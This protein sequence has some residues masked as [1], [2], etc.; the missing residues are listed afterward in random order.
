M[1]VSSVA[2]AN[3]RYALCPA[4]LTDGRVLSRAFA[5]L[6]ASPRHSSKMRASRRERTGSVLTASSPLSRMSWR[7]SL[8]CCFVT[9]LN[10]VVLPSQHAYPAERGL[11]RTTLQRPAWPLQRS[12][13]LGDCVVQTHGQAS[14]HKKSR[15]KVAKWNKRLAIVKKLLN[16]GERSCLKGMKE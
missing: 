7:L 13:F 1:K 14:M 11:Q 10:G 12:T 15:M 6:V 8:A 9:G 16:L 4:S 2:V 5:N 3:L